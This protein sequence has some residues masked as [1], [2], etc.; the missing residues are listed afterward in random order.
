MTKL[1]SFRQCNTKLIAENESPKHLKNIKEQLQFRLQRHIFAVI[2]KDQ[3]QK[4]N[5]V[6]EKTPSKNSLKTIIIS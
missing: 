2:R 6:L 5:I 1:R 4:K 3:S